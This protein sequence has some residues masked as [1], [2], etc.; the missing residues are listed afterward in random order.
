M[1]LDSPLL[2]LIV[3]A[4]GAI[5][6]ISFFFLPRRKS[7]EETGITPLYEERCSIRKSVGFGM[8][9]GGNLPLGRVSLYDNFMVIAFLWPTLIPYS[10]IERVEYKRHLL[11]KGIYIHQRSSRNQG[12][13]TLFPR[14]PEKVMEVLSSRVK[15]NV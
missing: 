11:S 13:I 1:L 15:V 10:E 5:I 2:A 3:I 12:V 9:A 4:F 7:H 14:Y 8:F 6:F